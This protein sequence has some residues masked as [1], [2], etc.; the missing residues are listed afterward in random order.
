MPRAQFAEV[1][2]PVT[3]SRPGATEGR[4]LAKFADSLVWRKRGSVWIAVPNRGPF[5]PS[6]VGWA[7]RIRLLN[8]F[9]STSLAG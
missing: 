9:D 8:F 2:K 7:I 6:M 5:H 4:G 3:K 1:A